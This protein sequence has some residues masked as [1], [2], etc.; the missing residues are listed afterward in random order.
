MDMMDNTKDMNNM[1]DMRIRYEALKKKE[2]STDLADSEREEL[3]QL[4]P[5]FEK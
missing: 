4:R 3:A 1:E 2:L 5:Y